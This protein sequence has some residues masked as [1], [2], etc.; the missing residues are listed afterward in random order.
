[1]FSSTWLY[2]V[3]KFYDLILSYFFIKPAQGALHAS[4]WELCWRWRQYVPIWLLPRIPALVILLRTDIIPILHLEKSFNEIQIQNIEMMEIQQ[5]VAFN[6]WLLS[7]SGP[8]G[9]LAGYPSGIVGWGLTLTRS[10]SASSVPFLLTSVST[11]CK[12]TQQCSLN[13]HWFDKDNSCSAIKSTFMMP[14]LS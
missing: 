5:S 14:V 13:M 12:W 11:T 6:D 8:C 4:Q 2:S 9:P 1:M 10:W 3:C 7:F